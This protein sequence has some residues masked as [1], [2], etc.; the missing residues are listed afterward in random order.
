MSQKE[1]RASV[2]SVRGGQRASATDTESIGSV[3]L[4]SLSRD[5]ERDRETETERQTDRER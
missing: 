3:L 1:A 4:L 5:G 2:D